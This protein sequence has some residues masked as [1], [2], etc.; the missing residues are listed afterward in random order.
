MRVLFAVSPGLDH[1]YPA[2]GLASAFRVAGHDVVVATAGVTVE[3]GVRAGLTVRDVAPGADFQSI[4]PKKGTP[5]ERTRAMRERGREITASGVTPDVILEKFGIVN[6]LMADGTL[7]FAQAWR[8]DLVVYSRLQGAALLTARALGIPAV[9]NG[10]SFLR[11]GDLPSRL[12]PHLAPGFER[13]GVPL[14][15]PPVTALYFAPQHMM[16]G[17]GE[18]WPMRFVPYHGGCVLPDWLAEPRTRKRVVVTLGTIV[19]GV[20]GVGSLSS[21]LAAARGVDAEVILALGDDPDLAPLGPLPDNVRVVGWTPL[22]ALLP[23]LDGIIHHGGAGTTLA[24]AHAGV[25]QLAMPYG[26]DNWINAEIAET[27]GVGLSKEPHEVD[28]GVLETLLHDEGLRKSA[29]ALA[30]ELAAQPGPD[31]MVPRLEALAH[32]ASQTASSRS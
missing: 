11:E 29:D 15:L 28:A 17:E 22:S 23:T 27:A 20:A 8:P 4:F 19:P 3:A 2:L 21:V 14:E 30:G 1:L 31:A 25:P 16:R 13:H 10:Y 6:D 24:A 5:Q 12:L 32:A 9:E 26:A 18:G 7:R